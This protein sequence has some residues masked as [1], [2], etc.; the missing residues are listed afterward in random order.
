MD[1]NAHV[2][3]GV[4][5]SKEVATAIQGA[6]I[7]AKLSVVPVQLLGKRLGKPHTVGHKVTGLCGSAPGCV[8]ALSL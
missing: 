5:C 4:R 7:L 8:L 1:N 6:I 3:L 2:G